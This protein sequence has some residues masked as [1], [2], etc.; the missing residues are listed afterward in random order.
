MKTLSRFVAQ[1]TSLIVAVLSC[2]DRVI[3][4]GHLPIANGP[5]LE[6]F[7]D[8][9]LKIRRCDSMA[10]A[11]RQSEVQVRVRVA[12][13]AVTN[14]LMVADSDKNSALSDKGRG[15]TRRTVYDDDRRPRIWSG[16][17]RASR[18]WASSFTPSSGL[19]FSSP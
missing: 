7:V 8:H 12:R 18:P 13:Q 17:V 19:V 9:V 6:G 16:A 4:N 15:P 3:F 5:A 14:D 10:V 2:F 11:D 1:F